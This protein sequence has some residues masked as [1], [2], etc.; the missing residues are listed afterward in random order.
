MVRWLFTGLPVS[1][2]G[3]YAAL[4]ILTF[5]LGAVLR[6][7]FLL[8]DGRLTIWSPTSLLFWFAPEYVAKPTLILLGV[9]A[10]T[11][12]SLLRGVARVAAG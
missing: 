5:A 9:R 7:G 4:G 8:T 2:L 11:R 1:L 6:V 3:V 10:P 12:R